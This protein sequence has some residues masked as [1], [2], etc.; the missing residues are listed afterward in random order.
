LCQNA[1]IR[2]VCNINKRIR[3]LLKGGSEMDFS[4]MLDGFTRGWGSS[5]NNIILWVLILLILLGDNQGFGGSLFGRKHK[6]RSHSSGGG[7]GLD[8]LGEDST[9][10][11]I[12]FIIIFV[13][14]KPCETPGT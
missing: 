12:I 9:F 14:C 4:N 3:K 10:I 5:S 6:K 13:L 2:I 7:F 8:F 11:I 1:F